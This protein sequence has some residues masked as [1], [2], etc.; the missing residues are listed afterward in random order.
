MK[1]INKKACF[2]FIVLLLLSFKI[3]AKHEQS[4]L[5][6]ENRNQVQGKGSSQTLK[7]SPDFGKLPLYFI[8]NEGQ[9]HEKA[10]FYARASRYTLWLTKQGLVFDSIKHK[11]SELLKDKYRH[12]PHASA[13]NSNLRITG[14]ES[15]KYERDVSRLIFLNANKNP[16]ITSMDRTAH[17]VN[18]FIG[19]EESKWKTNIPTS[20]TILYKE[21][22]KNID[23]KVYGIEGQI[24][25]D[26]IVR[27][28][29][30]P[31]NIQFEYENIKRTRINKDGDLII[32]T[33]FRKI[34][35]KKPV[36][37]Q[38]IDCKKVEVDAGF[39]KISKD[40][41]GLKV[42]KYNRNY[43][44]II[45]PV[46]LVYSTYLG[47]SENEYCYD[48][49][50]DGDGNAYVTGSTRST[51]FP[52]EIPFQDTLA[53][54]SDAFITKISSSGTS[55][56]YS[57]YLGGSSYEYGS[58]IAVDNT[59]SAYITGE[60]MSTDFPTKN[61]FQDTFGGG[62]FFGD[63]FV[64]KLSSDGT[65][66]VYSTYL[67]GLMWDVGKDIAVDSEGLAYVTGWTNSYNFPIHNAIQPTRPGGYYYGDAFVTKFSSSGTSLVYSTYLGGSG[68]DE[69]GYGITA[70]SEGAAYVTG[71]TE[72][73]D[74][75][76]QSPFQ[77]VYGGG[78]SDVFVT[79]FSSDGSSHIYSTYLGGSSGEKGYDVTVDGDG[80]AY[81]TGYTYSD[82][83]PLKN[84]FQAKAGSDAFVTK[85]SSNGT[86]LIYS[87][88]L[89]GSSSEYGKGIAAD[90][91]GAA[92]VTGYTYST[93]FPTKNA[94][95]GTSGGYTDAFVTKF[96]SSGTSLVYS[97]YLGGTGY[98]YGY[99]IAVDSTGA[100]YVSGY[101]DSIDFPVK[102]P[103][104][105][106]Q[107]GTDAF[108]TKLS[109]SQVKDDLL[110]T[111]DGSGVWYRN[112]ETGSWVKMSTP[113]DLVSAGDLDGDNTAD[114]IGVWSSGLWVKYSSSGSWARLTTLLPNDIA[115]GDMDGDGRDD[116]LGTWS[117]GVW[118]K[119]SVS[120]AWV[121]MSVVSA[122]L[123]AA[124][125][126]DGDNTDDLVGVWSSGLWVKLSSTGTWAKLTT[127]LPNQIASGD[128][129]GDGRDDVLGTWAS[130][131]WYK[132]SVSGTWVKMCSVPA[133]LVTA[134]DIDGDGTDDLIGTWSSGVWVKYSETGTWKKICTP[135]PMDIDAGLFRSGWGAGAMNFEGPIGGVY[136]EGPGTIDDY[137]DLSSEGLGG[138]N[139]AFQAEENLVPQEKGLKIMMRI[140]GPGEPGFKYIEQ[141][142]LVPHEGLVKKRG[143]KK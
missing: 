112:S 49:A 38:M 139:F 108:I 21:I 36:S 109:I 56:A 42:K 123:V 74:F 18:Y 126:L 28:G 51:D 94:Y 63:P 15:R 43:E 32:E 134:G 73:T 142:N 121:K 98:E 37:Y 3:S 22:Y 61:A 143:K 97:T 25:Y 57:T 45:D 26:W 35:H 128:M 99:G 129:N 17:R 40:A 78:G 20:K 2:L 14:D 124:G 91:G 103:Y 87:T 41:Y 79:K 105:R 68:D 90:S 84:P 113:A 86:N 132:D 54:S 60:T 77:E 122:N 104:Q 53:S 59:G 9:V 107:G 55:L 125:D 137:L 133:Y 88:Y 110:G 114:L 80:V 65:S 11:S 131:V 16:E 1:K 47:G 127:S 135:L 106:D 116:V 118:Y 136:A 138:W 111:W 120:G 69:I 19:K 140:P 66:L 5:I 44:L 85:F 100:A 130:G 72:S 50:V 89:G 6:P 34:V 93:D 33:E 12:V 10:L 81:V 71:Y 95:Q 48:V 23:L 102:N 67:G 8:P 4:R 31:E 7:L 82:D 13:Y 58:G 64:T 96:S 62:N 76:I 117:S 101:T 46:V 70:D 92:Y 29:G 119:N 75:P 30:N 52:M 24:E 141:K 115:S 27:P 83:F 39:E